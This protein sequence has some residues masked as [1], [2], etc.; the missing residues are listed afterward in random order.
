MVHTLREYAENMRIT[1]AVMFGEP[2]TNLMAVRSRLPTALS[3]CIPTPNEISVA[4]KGNE[5]PA[6]LL[7]ASRTQ[8]GCTFA[9]M[10]LGVRNSVGSRV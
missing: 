9:A 3:T 7:S 4:K 5:I 2:P 10:I 8:S 1:I 6:L